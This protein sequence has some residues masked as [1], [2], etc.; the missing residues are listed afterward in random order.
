MRQVARLAL[1]EDWS[2]AK[3]TSLVVGQAGGLPEAIAAYRSRLRPL[4]ETEP[5]PGS[6]HKTVADAFAPIGAKMRPDM[7]VD[8]AQVWASAMVAAL[9]DLP[10]WVAVQALKEGVH[11][12]YDFPSEMEKEVRRIAD[13]IMTRHRRALRRMELLKDAITRPDRLLDDPTKEPEKPLSLD[14]VRAI[15][16]SGAFSDMV[17]RVGVANGSILAE[18]LE[19]VK[20]ELQEEQ[21]RQC[22]EQE[23][24]IG[25][26][27]PSRSD[28]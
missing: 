22:A 4:R 10:D 3:G 16:R 17:L 9:S 19:I 2:L 6:L 25:S 18:D 15:A 7:S 27:P 13:G 23:S 24:S 1:S 8:A 21:P 20:G 28:A 11:K 26:S 12:P 5:R 14:E